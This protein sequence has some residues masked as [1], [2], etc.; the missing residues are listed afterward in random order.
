[1]SKA[2]PKSI[3]TPCLISMSLKL[4]YKLSMNFETAEL[5]CLLSKS[6]LI[7][8]EQIVASKSHSCVARTFSHI[9]DMT[10]KIE[11][12]HLSYVKVWLVHTIHG[13]IISLIG[14]VIIGSS[15]INLSVNWLWLR[16]ICFYVV[17]G[18][19]CD[20]YTSYYIAFIVCF[21]I[22]HPQIMMNA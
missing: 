21:I 7:L 18:G 4:F 3:K 14:W 6:N 20:G 10:I 16:R 12:F 15:H 11:I 17:V 9:F 19:F 1:M 22:T 2:L 5:F 13:C 8:V